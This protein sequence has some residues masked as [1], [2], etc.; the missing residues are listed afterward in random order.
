MIT[1][2]TQTTVTATQQGAAGTGRPA[3]PQGFDLS[4]NCFGIF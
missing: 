1:R 3:R 2:F 4:V